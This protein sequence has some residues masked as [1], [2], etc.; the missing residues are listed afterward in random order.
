MIEKH[1]PCSC[2]A[3]APVVVIE[4]TTQQPH[5]IYVYGHWIDSDM[6]VCLVKKGEG[7][8][9]LATAGLVQEHAKTRLPAVSICMEY[10]VSTEPGVDVAMCALLCVAYEESVHSFRMRHQS[11]HDRQGGTSADVALARSCPYC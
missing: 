11:N 4:C 7:G 6:E 1:K 8:R 5:T 10:E 9:R 2:S 3:V